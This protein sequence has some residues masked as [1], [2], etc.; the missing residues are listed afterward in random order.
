MEA[1]IVARRLCAGDTLAERLRGVDLM[2]SVAEKDRA[3]LVLRY[4]R[5]SETDETL[6]WA[7]DG[8][9]AACGEVEDVG[10]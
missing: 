2:R 9:L 6:L 10:R 5:A 7:I 8:A 3:R 4:L 1:F